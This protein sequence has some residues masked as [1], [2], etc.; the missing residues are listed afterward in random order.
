MDL[1]LVKYFAEDFKK[2]Y[3]LDVFG[4]PKRQLRLM[5]DVEKVKKMMST[6]TTRVP[7]NIEC[8]AEDKD[9]NSGIKR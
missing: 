2:R 1:H 9:V 8:F 4:Y 7:L 5:N 6:V 3:K